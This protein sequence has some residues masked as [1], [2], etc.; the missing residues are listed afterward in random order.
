MHTESLIFVQDLAIIMVIASLTTMLCCRLKQPIV[1][2]YIL[3]GIIIGPHTPPFSFITNEIS[4]QSLAELGVIFLLFSLGLEFNLRNLTKVGFAATITALIEIICMTALGYWVGIM[5][6]W[7]NINSLFLGAILAISSTTIIIKTL[8]ELG[9]KKHKFSQ[10]IF[11]I[12]IIEDIFAILILAL[13]S[14]ISVSGTLEIKEFI[15]TAIELSSFL[16]VSLIIGLLLIPR[17]ILHII[18]YKNSE[19]LLISILGLCFGFCLLVIKF[20]YSIALGAFII[21]AIIAE[22]RDIAKIELSIKPIRD[23]F[24]SIFFVSVGLLF[25]P[26]IFM[27]YLTP[28][29]VITLI[30]I[31]GKIISCSIGMLLTGRDGKTSVKIGMAMAQIGE[32]SFIIASL[33]LT[34]KVTGYFLYSIAVS[35]SIITTLLTPYLIK[36][37]DTITKKISY[38]VPKSI[39]HTFEIYVHWIQHINI[40]EQQLELTNILKRSLIQMIVNLFIV[41]AIFLSFAYLARTDLGDIIGQVTGIYMKKTII[42]AAAS[43]LSLPFLIATYRKIKALSLLLAELTI[44]DQ[45]YKQLTVTA[46]NIISEI[47]PITAILIIMLLIALL[48]ASILPPIELLILITTVAIILITFIFPWL[49][50]LHARL[51]ISLIESLN[52]DQDK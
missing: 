27:E 36:Y 52:K 50:K 22:S 40:S 7:S 48:S 37:S 41:I 33:G 47:I 28:I 19:I 5:F 49:I 18:K 26:N 38:Y 14:T 46:R 29:M 21:G 13:L 15:M 2:G 35:V 16:V 44:K 1:I 9:L 31:I 43:L 4:I 42:W 32:F 45:T 23:M 12:L 8:D 25:D 3:A 11:G 30:V 20:N 10:L 6:G 51:Q 39:S 24:S 34:L 17:L